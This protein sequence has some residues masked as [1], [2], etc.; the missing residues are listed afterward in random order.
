[1]ITSTT[2]PEMCGNCGRYIYPHETPQ[3]W[4]YR[5]VCVECRNALE[6]QLAYASPATAVDAL[7]EAARAAAPARRPR[8]RRSPWTYPLVVGVA[9]AAVVGLIIVTNPDLAKGRKAGG[10]GGVN[11]PWQRSGTVSGSAWV[12]RG[13]ASSDL[14]RGLQ[15]EIIKPN[16]SRSAAAR[17]IQAEVDAAE[18]DAKNWRELADRYRG[19]SFMQDSVRSDDD[20]A[21]EA[22]A[23]AQKLRAAISQLTGE[24]PVDELFRLCQRPPSGGVS[25]NPVIEESAVARVTTDAEGKYSV[26]DLS[27][28][29]YFIHAVFITELHAVQWLVPVTVSG[30]DV[31]IDLFNDNAVMIHNRRIF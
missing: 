31:K 21:D 29:K 14:L 11:M 26:E 24:M 4:N 25:L 8:K 13:N 10:S 2:S 30:N 3:V 16:A 9:A 15:I 27:N 19:D 20:R 6:R 23:R 22:R 17:V 12:I 18:L 1:M 5:V 28:G 7:A